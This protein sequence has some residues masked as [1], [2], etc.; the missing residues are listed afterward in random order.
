M[1]DRACQGRFARQVQALGGQH[2]VAARP[3]SATRGFAPVARRR[4]IERTFAWLECFRR[5]A[6]AYERTPA[7]HGAWLL[8]ANLTTS[9]RRATA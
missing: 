1:T 9:R 4:V 8:V 5:L 3:P 7:S 6:V 2:R